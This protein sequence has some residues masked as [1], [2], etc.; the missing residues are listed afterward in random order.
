MTMAHHLLNCSLVPVAYLTTF[1]E[2]LK[3][4]IEYLGDREQKQGPY[5]LH[6]IPFYEKTAAKY[7]RKL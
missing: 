3:D 6:F 1:R 7:G 4:R 5:K 2:M